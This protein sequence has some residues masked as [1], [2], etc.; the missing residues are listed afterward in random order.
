MTKQ[1][2]CLVDQLFGSLHSRKTLLLV[3]GGSIPASKYKSFLCV[4]FKHPVIARHDLFNSGSS[5]SRCAELHLS[6][7]A[8]N[9]ATNAVVLIELAFI[10]IGLGVGSWIGNP[11]IAVQRSV[12][13][14]ILRDFTRMD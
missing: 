9:S 13:A 8:S 7:G 5:I 10:G 12:L 4:G 6:T 11:E 2:V 14:I 1:G 3:S